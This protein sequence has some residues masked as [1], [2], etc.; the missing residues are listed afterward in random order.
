MLCM[1]VFGGKSMATRVRL[2]ALLLC[3]V[4]SSF[5][6]ASDLSDSMQLFFD[7][8]VQ[9]AHQNLNYLAT[10]GSLDARVFYFR[11]LANHRLGKSAAASDDFHK[12][13]MLELQGGG[14]GVGQALQRVQGA[15]R[16]LLEKHR[17]MARLRTRQRWQPV[18][19]QPAVARNIPAE[20]NPTLSPS[21]L[22]ASAPRF[23]LASEVPLRDLASDRYAN[24][25][26]SGMLV[27]DERSPAAPMLSTSTSAKDD[28]PVG[29]GVV[30]ASSTSEIDAEDPFG[31]GTDLS[32]ENDI[33][34][35]DDEPASGSSGGTSSGFFG[36]FR[37]IG[38]ALTPKIDATQVLPQG[39]PIPGQGGPGPAPS[40]APGPGGAPG[41]PAGGDDFPFE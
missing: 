7:G 35:S 6:V 40:G 14:V 12:A 28:A 19:P 23:R 41:G 17:T 9:Q 22:V 30:Q 24:Q 37:A 36:A 3:V 29:T 38:K 15:E 27:K 4:A 25:P 26:A 34:S 32:A 11:G 1:N 16:L 2:G 5:A 13:A 20:L 39:L 31:D 33:F 8:R 21:L 10:N 18:A